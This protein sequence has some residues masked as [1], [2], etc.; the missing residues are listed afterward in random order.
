MAFLNYLFGYGEFLNNLLK[1]SLA[2]EFASSSIYLL[3]VVNLST[4]WY[5]VVKSG[6][7]FYIFAPNHLKLFP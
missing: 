7:I 6:Y 3:K 1:K 2:F 5:K 4:K